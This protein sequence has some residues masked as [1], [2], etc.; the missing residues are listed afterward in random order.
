MERI[1][2]VI[3]VYNSQNT[4]EEVINRIENAVLEFKKKYNFEIILINDFSRDNSFYVCKRICSIKPFVKLISLARNF[5]QHNA[6]MAGFSYAAGDYII[7]LDDDLQTPP[8]EAYKLLEE[9]KNGNYDLVFAKYN[10]KRRSIF[11]NFGSWVNNVMA[12]MLINK[13]SNI[14]MGS[15]FIARRF[16]ISEILKYEGAYPYIGGLLLRVTCNVGNVIVNHEERKYGKSNYTVKKL[17]RLWLN[18][19][20]NFSIKPLRLSSFTGFFLALSSFIWI[21]VLAVKKTL[22]PQTQLG[23]TSTMI[24]IIFFGGIQLISTG[25]LGEYIGRA[26]LSINKAP[27]YVIRDTCNINRDKEA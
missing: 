11:R 20:T 2:F 24:C 18:G 8:E 7:C 22:I 4:I 9:L 19:F 17:L 6:L 26:F 14:S 3:P 13:P 5:G 25:L 27:Q 21:I 12:N 23:W 16:L 10:I 1:S 15:F